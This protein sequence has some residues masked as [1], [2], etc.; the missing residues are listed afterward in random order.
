MDIKSG[1]YYKKQIGYSNRVIAWSHAARFKTA[2]KLIGKAPG[3]TL[4]DYGSGDGTFIGMAEGRFARACGADISD[5]QVKDCNQRFG[6]MAGVGFVHIDDLAGAQHDNAY[7]VITCMETLEPVMEQHIPGIFK[8]FNRVAKPGAKIIISVP[9]E[10]GLTFLLKNGVRRLDGLRPN[11]PYKHYERYTVANGLKMLLADE[12]TV[13]ERP[14]YGEPG[15]Q[16][17]S[18]YGFNWKHL[19]KQLGEYFTVEK[20][21]FSPVGFVGQG[22]LSSQAWMICSPRK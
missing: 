19:R 20:T 3:T 17:Y 21:L 11:S 10:T 18:H 22:H 16:G 1:H 6:H 7:D 14:A 13:L 5:Y 9:I 8:T 15:K 12:N 4:L 2:L